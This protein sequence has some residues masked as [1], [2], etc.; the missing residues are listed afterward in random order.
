ML[1]F[2]LPVLRKGAE[3]VRFFGLIMFSEALKIIGA[4]YRN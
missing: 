1:R 2:D 3:G 4:V